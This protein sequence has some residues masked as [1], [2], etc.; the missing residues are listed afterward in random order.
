MKKKKN[1]NFRTYYNQLADLN[2]QTELRDEICKEIGIAISTFYLKLRSNSFN[3]LE[4]KEIAKITG[5]KIDELF[6]K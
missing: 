1:M 5:K 4:K 3:Y 2:P 6:P